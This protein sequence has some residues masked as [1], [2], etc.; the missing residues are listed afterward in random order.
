MVRYP[1]TACLKLEDVMVRATRETDTNRD[2]M[3]KWTC[4]KFDTAF[5]ASSPVT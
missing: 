3:G 2:S 4:M 5:V 1:Y